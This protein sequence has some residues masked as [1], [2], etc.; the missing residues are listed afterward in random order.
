MEKDDRRAVKCFKAAATKGY[1]LAY[2]YL[3]CC[4]INNI[5]V[6]EKDYS[7]A[8]SFF[9]LGDNCGE[10]NAISWLGYCYYWG[11]GERQDYTTAVAYLEEAISLGYA[12]ALHWLGEC[13][14]NGYGVTQDTAYANYL[15]DEAYEMIPDDIVYEEAIY[16]GPV[17]SGPLYGDTLFCQMNIWQ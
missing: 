17:Y 5:G 13:Y 1:D 9:E 6:G 2:C 10:V 8:A 3:G 14:E 7:K 4:Y 12:Q 15:H 16:E 11:F